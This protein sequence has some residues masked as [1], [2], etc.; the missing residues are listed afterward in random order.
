M[1]FY[2]PDGN[3]DPDDIVRLDDL[4]ANGSKLAIASRF[5][6]GA[7]NEEADAIRPRARVNK[8]LRR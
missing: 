1:V 8:R 5:A 4:V 6:T 2:S 7:V 3:E